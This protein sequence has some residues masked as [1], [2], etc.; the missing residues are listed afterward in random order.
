MFRGAIKKKEDATEGQ[1]R[2]VKLALGSALEG[3]ILDVVGAKMAIATLWIAND[4]KLNDY[5]F[6]CCC[7]LFSLHRQICCQSAL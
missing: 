3:L 2:E 5:D 1:K 6:A 4:L 7:T